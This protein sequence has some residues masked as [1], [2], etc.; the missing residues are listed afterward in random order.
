MAARWLEIA[1]EVG[2]VQG[3]MIHSGVFDI[4]IYIFILSGRDGI[5]DILVRRQRA[6]I[7]LEGDTMRI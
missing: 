3:P 4:Y 1:P 2:V 5:L 7:T 6:K